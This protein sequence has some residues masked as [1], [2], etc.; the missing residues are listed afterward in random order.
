MEKPVFVEVVIEGQAVKRELNTGAAVSIPFKTYAGQFSHLPLQ[1]TRTKPKTYTGERAFQKG[2][3][4][5]RAEKDAVTEEL[6]LL[7][8][9]AV[10]RKGSA[11]PH[12]DRMGIYKSHQREQRGGKQEIG[13]ASSQVS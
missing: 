11:V 13:K 9:D 5:V 6:S 7:V 1:D 8:V 10:A 4:M 3:I 12:S 2:Q